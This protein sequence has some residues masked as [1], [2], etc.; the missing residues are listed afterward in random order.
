MLAPLLAEA[1]K[2]PSKPVHKPARKP[3]TPQTRSR[4]AAQAPS[5]SP[6]TPA[7]SWLDLASRV[8]TRD[9]YGAMTDDVVTAKN[10]GG[11]A[12]VCFPRVDPA[13]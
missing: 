11:S 10:N 13:C 12:V 2:T 6:A 8:A 4:S 1:L 9:P 7:R 3:A 5:G